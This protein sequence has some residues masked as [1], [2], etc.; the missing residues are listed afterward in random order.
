MNEVIPKEQSL[1]QPPAQQDTGT[2]PKNKFSWRFIGFGIILV[3][4]MGI[5]IGSLL[6]LNR[7][8]KSNIINKQSAPL[9]QQKTK[10]SQSKL[11]IF[12][13]ILDK[14]CQ[15]N[16][17]DPIGSNS[18]RSADWQP[19]PKIDIGTLPFTIIEPERIS[20]IECDKQNQT[21][22]LI[23]DSKSKTSSKVGGVSVIVS[24][25][26]FDDEDLGGYNKT[27]SHAPP[28]QTVGMLSFYPV[29]QST[30]FSQGYVGESVQLVVYAEKSIIIGSS[31]DD[32]IYFKTSA[33]V[34]ESNDKKLIDFLMPYTEIKTINVNDGPKRVITRKIPTN[35]ITKQFFSRDLSIEERQVFDN[36][37]YTFSNYTSKDTRIIPS[38]NKKKYTNPNA[39]IEFDYSNNWALTSEFTH[40]KQDEAVIWLKNLSKG[41]DIFWFE[42]NRSDGA[43]GFGAVIYTEPV[44][45]DGIETKLSVRNHCWTEEMHIFEEK[46]EKVFGF[47]YIELNHGDDFWEFSGPDILT[48]EDMQE[49]L[50][51]VREIISTVKFTN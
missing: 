7:Q 20:I 30:P 25:Q 18:S 15:L 42:R 35:P 16:N 13:K 4:V 51:L 37:E 10:D 48:R 6:T 23:G 26:S 21:S 40:P 1:I 36:I 33:V 34:R 49:K 9:A 24:D 27:F 22:I 12:Q 46:C 17:I 32:Q 50:K 41:D 39:R 43:G 29:I 38:A 5:G 44:R 28:L 8:Q 3:I 31:G 19:G 14:N 45:I 2:Y 11:S 47:A